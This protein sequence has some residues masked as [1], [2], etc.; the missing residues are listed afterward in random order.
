MKKNQ[1]PVREWLAVVGVGAAFAVALVAWTPVAAVFEGAGEGF[2]AAVTGVPLAP[3]KFNI[4][5]KGGSL[6]NPEVKLWWKN[7]SLG[8]SIW[9]MRSDDGGRN[10]KTIAKLAPTSTEYTDKAVVKGG[11]YS[12]YIL[13]QSNAGKGRASATGIARLPSKKDIL[14]VL[15]EFKDL[16]K[17]HSSETPAKVLEKIVGKNGSINSYWK[18]N[19][20]NRWIDLTADVSDWLYVD[21]DIA[22]GAPKT[23]NALAPYL[24]K[25]M[26]E[27]GKVA[28]QNGYKLA[29][30]SRIVFVTPDDLQSQCSGERESVYGLC[31]DLADDMARIDGNRIVING[32]NMGD[33]YAHEYGHLMLMPQILRHPALIKCDG[34]DIAADI[35]ECSLRPVAD[36]TLMGYHSD[37]HVLAIVKDSLRLL[38]PYEKQTVTKTGYYRVSTMEKVS[39]QIPYP[40]ALF[41]QAPN[42]NTYVVEY[43]QPVGLDADEA[44]NKDY[45]GIWITMSAKVTGSGKSIEFPAIISYAN[46]V[47]AKDGTVFTDDTNASKALRIIQVAHNRD[48]ATV[49]VEYGT[50]KCMP[51]TPKTLQRLK[52]LVTGE[53]SPL[54]GAA[55][56]I[57]S[58]AGNPDAGTITGTTKAPAGDTELVGSFPRTTYTITAEKN[59]WQKGTKT[60]TTSSNP[61]SIETA[62]IDLVRTTPT[63]TETDIP[64][65]TPIDT[66]SPSPTYSGVPSW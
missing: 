31:I 16:R 5:A 21:V 52:V 39:E 44:D 38:Y 28:E 47:A 36:Y 54:V 19:S 61:N 29:D 6:R 50:E 49:C 32:D 18:E 15:V 64:S 13:A 9:V 42:G 12:Y 60:F 58:A 2:A 34:K 3:T 22:K 45:D 48:Y 24:K 14:A 51:T 17:S 40:R 63:P 10:F 41:V 23:I 25:K 11:T 53:G 65:D 27:A 7:N 55:V 1:Q 26:D 37:A 46:D 59:G 30:Y 43:R 35:T 62:T 4:D 57:V 8:S 66:Y 33:T 20:Y 56:T